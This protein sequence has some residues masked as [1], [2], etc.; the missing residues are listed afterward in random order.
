MRWLRSS[1]VLIK[2]EETFKV[3]NALIGVSITLKY[4]MG[5]FSCDTGA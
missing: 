4:I 1:L 5:F 2:Y 3:V